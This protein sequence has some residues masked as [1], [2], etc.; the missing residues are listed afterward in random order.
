MSLCDVLKTQESGNRI[1]A[2]ICAA[3]CVLK[4]YNIAKGK[5]LTSYPSVKKDLESD[6]TYID[7]EIV[8]VDGKLF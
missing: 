7:N 1:I 5:K 4:A 8:V 2:A 3:S 6:Y